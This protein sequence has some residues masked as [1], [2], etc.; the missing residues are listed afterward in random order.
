[1]AVAFVIID[2]SIH[3]KEGIVEYQKLAPLTITAFDGKFVAR[4]GQT[5]TL[6]GDWKPERMVIIEFPSVERANEWWNSEMYSKAKLIRQKTAN[7]KMIIV[8]GI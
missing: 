5:T 7:T 1:M 3:N 8:E 4:G 6:E 2:L